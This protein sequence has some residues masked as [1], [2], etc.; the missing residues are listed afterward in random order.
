MAGVTHFNGHPDDFDT[1]KS[2]LRLENIDIKVL[3][4]SA[5]NVSYCYSKYWERSD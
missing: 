2:L 5:K 3:L 4:E 1:D